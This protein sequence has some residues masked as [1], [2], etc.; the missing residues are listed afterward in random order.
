[1]EGDGG[2]LLFCIPITSWNMP[3]MVKMRILLSKRRKATLEMGFQ[4]GLNCGGFF[5]CK[6]FQK[7]F[8]DDDSKD[9]GKSRHRY[10]L[11]MDV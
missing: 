8:T 6:G 1:M 9:G 4:M 10:V 5:S 11:Q 7:T 2:S 3:A